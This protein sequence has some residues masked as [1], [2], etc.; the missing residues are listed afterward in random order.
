MAFLPLAQITS[1]G[2]GTKFGC[3]GVI[4]W[5]MLPFKR[6]AQF[7]GR[8]GRREFWWF[9]LFLTVV[10]IALIFFGA[11]LMT[12][13]E[14]PRMG[15]VIAI[16]WFLFFVGTFLP[17]LALTVRRFHDLGV[18]GHLTWV[19]YLAMFFFNILAWFGY[20]IVMAL[21]GKPVPNRYGRPVYDEDLPSVF[22]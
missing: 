17:G 12:G 19:V 7:S 14:E 13:L 16:G 20:L 4:G 22:S 3:S 5:M 11:A 9:S 15:M 1:N 10:Y 8:S 6:Y 18:S 21:P 2:P